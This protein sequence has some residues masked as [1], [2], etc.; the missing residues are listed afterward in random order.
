MPSLEKFADRY[1]GP[2]TSYR[3]NRRFNLAGNDERVVFMPSA[4]CQAR[5]ERT[6]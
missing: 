2:F 1:L 4:S 6:P 5:P 3:F